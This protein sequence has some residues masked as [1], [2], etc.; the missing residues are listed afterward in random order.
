MVWR[1]GWIVIDA[2]T[3]ISTQKCLLFPLHWLDDITKIS[4]TGRRVS[5]EGA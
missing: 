3:R 1:V 2:C 4:C 5:M